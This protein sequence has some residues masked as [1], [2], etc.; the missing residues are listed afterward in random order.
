[1]AY[2]AELDETNN[3]VTLSHVKTVLGIAE[4]DTAPIDILTDLINDASWFFNDET[5]RKLKAQSLTEY[6]DGP[7][8][9]ILYLKNPPVSE[10][11]LSQDVARDF[12]ATTVIATT[13]YELD[14]AT[15]RIFLTGDVFSTEKHVI[16]AVYTGGYAMVPYD[17]QR[18]AIA[19]ITQNYLLNDHK[20]LATKSRSNDK[21][22]TT[23]YLHA[24][25]PAVERALKRYTRTVA[26]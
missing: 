10:L 20:A 9:Y 26:V 12:G 17:L 19:M 4:D 13:D 24:T 22:G 6:Y 7:G 23:S 3:L 21:G 1:M 14:A 5:H 18:A 8:G 11:T 16:K 2:N 15:G 25:L